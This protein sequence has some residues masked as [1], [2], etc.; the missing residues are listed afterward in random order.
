MEGRLYAFILRSAKLRDLEE[1]GRYALHSHV[2]LAAPNE[3]ALRGRSRL[4]TDDAVLSA[5]GG[6]WYF[7]VDD[8]YRLVEFS[9]ASALLGERAGP[10]D[11][12]PRYTT[13]SAPAGA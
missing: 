7:E 2:D 4:V 8:G 12:P 9:I 10:D 13:W 3:F 1:D 6:A 11:W 5:V